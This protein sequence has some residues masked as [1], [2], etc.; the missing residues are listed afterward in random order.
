MGRKASYDWGAIEK[1]YR[2]GTLSNRQ[3]AEKFECGESAIRDRAK[4]YLWT[5]DLKDAVAQATAQKI[6]RA[7]LRTKLR[8][9]Y[10]PSEKELVENASDMQTDRV[11][12]HR[13]LTVEGLEVSAELLSQIKAQAQ[14]ANPEKLPALVSMFKDWS[15]GLKPLVLTDRLNHGLGDKPAEKAP[16]NPANDAAAAEQIR[17]VHKL[18]TTGPMARPGGPLPVID[19]PPA[20]VANGANG[21]L[22]GKGHK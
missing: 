8:T 6:L 12:T 1:V 20:K 16:E 14:E 15:T 13:S 21:A 7:G 5:R 10:A 4:R 19:Q 22:N 2:T 18:L 3:I 9:S 17:Y 11:L